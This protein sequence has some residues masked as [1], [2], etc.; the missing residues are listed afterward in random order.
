M[1]CL[2]DL[3]MTEDDSTQVV[4]T[5]VTTNNSPSQNYTNVDDQPTTNIDSINTNC[6]TD[7][8]MTV[9]TTPHRLSKRHNL[10]G[11]NDQPGQ[12]TSCKHTLSVNHI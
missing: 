3:T 1:N 10:L 12:L 4:Q 9:K 2:T 6:L 11:I 7:L 5:S 8:T